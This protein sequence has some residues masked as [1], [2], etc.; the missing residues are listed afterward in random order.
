MTSRPTAVVVGASS[1]IGASTARALAKAGYH[2]HLLARRREL[3]EE[4]ATVIEGTYG[5][6]D[7]TCAEQIEDELVR[8]AEARSPVALGVY[9]AGVLEVSP[10]S[11]HP[12]DMWRRVVDVNLTGAFFFARSIADHLAPGSRLVFVSSVSGS[13]GQPNLAAYAASKGGLDRFA[14]SLSAEF[15]TRGIGVHVI[16]PGPVATPLLARPGTPEFQ[17]EADQVAEIIVWLAALPPDVVLREIVVRA[18]TRGP[19]ARSRHESETFDGKHQ[20]NPEGTDG[21]FH[22]GGAR[23]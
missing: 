17:L 11:G 13:K 9:A 20:P 16:A 5:V 23:A 19:Y 22:S 7:V 10:I 21:A 15:E 1:G 8:L 4:L 14:E 3:L 6:V 2:V 12:I 18:V